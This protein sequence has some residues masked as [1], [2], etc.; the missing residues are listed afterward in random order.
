M[1]RSPRTDRSHPDRGVEAEAAMQ[2]AVD[3]LADRAELMGWSRDETAHA[4]L[5]LAVARIL[6]IEANRSTDDAI[7]AAVAAVHGLEKWHGHG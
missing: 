2:D 6:A 7:R 5:N 1:I 3:A 4:L